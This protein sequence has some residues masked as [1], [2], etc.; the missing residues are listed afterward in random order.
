MSGIQPTFVYGGISY[1]FGQ[2]TSQHVIQQVY[3]LY[4]ASNGTG[5]M[6]GYMMY[7]P[8]ENNASYTG[9]RAR[10]TGHVIQVQPGMQQHVSQQPLIQVNTMQ[11]Y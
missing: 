1:S 7:Q 4:Y 10:I 5:G 3:Q 8:V 2:Q 11:V 9:Y 6:G